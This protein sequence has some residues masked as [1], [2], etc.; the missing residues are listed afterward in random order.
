M[1]TTP[2]GG[3]SADISSIVKD[4]FWKYTWDSLWLG[5]LSGVYKKWLI[6]YSGKA[7]QSNT[8]S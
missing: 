5:I 4:I 7:A 1:D 8:S 2:S 3:Q 6:W